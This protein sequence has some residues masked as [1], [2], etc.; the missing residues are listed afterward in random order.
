MF[1]DSIDKQPKDLTKLFYGNDAGSS[2][3]LSLMSTQ[4]LHLLNTAKHSEGQPAFFDLS[5]FQLKPKKKSDP[6]D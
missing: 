6:R 4:Q 3:E 2:P 5:D 1:P